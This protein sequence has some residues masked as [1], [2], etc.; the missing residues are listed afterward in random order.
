[1]AVSGF[2]LVY[3]TD[4]PTGESTFH[5]LRLAKV[6]RQGHG[7]VCLTTKRAKNPQLHFLCFCVQ[8]STRSTLENH[9]LCILWDK[10]TGQQHILQILS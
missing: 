4:Y 2:L 6:L 7:L 8:S 10:T 5:E 3:G 1:M 9:I